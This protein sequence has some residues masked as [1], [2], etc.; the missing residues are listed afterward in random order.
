MLDVL[1]VEDD[2]IL[3]DFLVEEVQRLPT[4]ADRPVRRAASLAEAR[5]LLAES[6]PDWILL[7]LLLPDGSGLDLA[8]ELVEVRPDARIVVL[9]GCPAHSELPPRLLPHLQAVLSKAEGLTPLREAIWSLSRDLDDT[10]PD[11]S[12]LSPRQ[13]QMLLLIGEGLDTAEIAE[14][15]GISFA[16]A[17]THRRQ[18]TGRLGVKGARLVML[19]R[20]LA[21]SR[22]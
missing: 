13:R 10:L 4:R 17:Q 2:P 3:L 5:R 20:E 18:I 12:S 15:L 22:A 1:V 6:P 8:R 7:D 14:R 16:T 21:R 9:S 19:A 11:L